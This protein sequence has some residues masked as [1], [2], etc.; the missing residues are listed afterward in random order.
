V[1]EDQVG[2]HEREPDRQDDLR[3]LPPDEPVQEQ[4]LE[5]QPEQPDQEE[6]APQSDP[7]AVGA[8][9]Q[10]ERD[11]APQ[12]VEGTVRQVERPHEPERQRESAGDQ[13]Q[14]G[15]ERQA[16]HGPRQDVLDHV[17]HTPSSCRPTAGLPWIRRRA[18]CP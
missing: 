13:E 4:P 18:S 7:V 15:S 6:R 11:V 9:Q 2:D 12:Q 10:V 8:P 1:A 14:Q 17:R 16:V 3:Q 5:D